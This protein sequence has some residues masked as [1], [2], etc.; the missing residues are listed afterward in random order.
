M[1]SSKKTAVL[2]LA[3][4]FLMGTAFGIFLNHAVLKKLPLRP[5]HGSPGDFVFEKFTR[6]LS[7]TSV[8]QDSLKAMLDELKEQFK[9][10][11]QAHFQHMEEIRLSFNEKFEQ[12][13]TEEQKSKYREMVAGFERERKSF[14]HR[15]DRDRT[16]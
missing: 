13:L 10:A 6:D 11:G 8:Q 15:R 9:E 7:L 1:I 16:E 12:I 3:T 5:K 2:I 4:V 14:N